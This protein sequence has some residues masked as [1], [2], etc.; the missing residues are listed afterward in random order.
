[1][2]F[3]TKDEEPLPV[4]EE[5][6]DFLRDPFRIAR[7]DEDAGARAREDVARSWNIARNNREATGQSLENDTGESLCSRQH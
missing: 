5:K 6:F 7:R 3:L 4:L 2:S 1:M